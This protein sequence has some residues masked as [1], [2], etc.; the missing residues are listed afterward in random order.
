MKSFIKFWNEVSLVTKIFIGL[1][2]GT[3]LGFWF[4]NFTVISVLGDI[5]VGAL[6]SIAPILVFTLVLSS[7]AQNSKRIGKMFFTVIFLYMLNTFL[8]ATVAIIA[9]FVF[10]VSLNFEVASS[11]SNVPSGISEVLQDLLVNIV[12]NPVDAISKANYMGILFWAIIFGFFS[13]Q[14]LLKIPNKL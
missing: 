9:S 3:G 6:K 13:N 12:A 5:F 11:I 14:L 1:I 2:I 10:P 8:S 7:L 4:P